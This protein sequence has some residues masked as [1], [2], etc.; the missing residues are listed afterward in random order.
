MSDSV[1]TFS[2]GGSVS[3][4]G[5]DATNLYRVTLLKTGLNLYKKSGIILTRGLTI[6]RMM[7]MAS[8][9]TKKKYK[10]TQIDMAIQDLQEWCEAM[11]CAMPIVDER[12]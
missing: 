8:D 12:K 1:I 9:V 10:R 11:K 5:E 7:Q 2:S 6:T 4:V 3:F